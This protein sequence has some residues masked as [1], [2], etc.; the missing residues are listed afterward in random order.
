MVRW[1]INELLLTDTLVTANQLNTQWARNLQ[2]IYGRKATTE[3]IKKKAKQITINIELRGDNRFDMESSIRAELENSPSI[4]V[5]SDHDYVYENTQ[6]CWV[7]PTGFNVTDPGAKYPLKCIITGLVDEQTI[8]SCQY[9]TEW[10]NT[11]TSVYAETFKE[12]KTRN[13]D[14]ELWEY[15]R[16]KYG[17]NQ[18]T[19]EQ[20]TTPNTTTWTAP[21]SIDLSGASALCC[22]QWYFDHRDDL[23]TAEVGLSDSSTTMYYDVIS[24]IEDDWVWTY[25]QIPMVAFAGLDTSAIT[26]FVRRVDYDSGPWYDGIGWVWVI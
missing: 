9:A 20:T 6:H 24:D 12:M 11:D 7:V 1:Y 13:D 19:T 26:G 14:Q 2:P 22:W 18:I 21:Y 23:T 5:E 15:A 8:T 25:H 17:K 4:W 10:T 16:S 3:T